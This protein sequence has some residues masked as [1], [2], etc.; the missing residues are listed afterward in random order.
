[1]IFLIRFMCYLVVLFVLELLQPAQAGVIIPFTQTIAQLCAFLVHSWD[2]KVIF[3]GIELINSQ[4]G[5]AVSI[6]AGCNGV[7]AAIVLISAILAFPAPWMVRFMGV[8]IGFV[9][10][11]L[12]NIVRIISLFYLGQW[13]YDAFNW[14]H[15]YI[16]QVLIMLDVLIIFLLWLHYTPRWVRK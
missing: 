8:V 3:T 7:E 15:L 10:V 16:W 13:N 5:F 4:T 12:L 11:Q 2:D 9:S 6:Q 1:M 14:A